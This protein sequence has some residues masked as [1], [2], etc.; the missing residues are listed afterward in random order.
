M[1][2]NHIIVIF[3]IWSDEPHIA[4]INLFEPW[5]SMKEELK[6]CNLIVVSYKDAAGGLTVKMKAARRKQKGRK[7]RKKGY[8][9]LQG[10]Q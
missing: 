1:D 3:C 9:Q 10:V 5:V 2:E 4:W 8:Q 6:L 7:E